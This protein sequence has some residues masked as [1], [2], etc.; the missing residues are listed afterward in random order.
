MAKEINHIFENITIEE[1][2][3][4]LKEQR[5]KILNEFAKAYL[6][7]TGLLP[8]EVELVSSQDCK[9]FIIE[10]VYSFRKKV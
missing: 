9:G 10:T 4:K 2:T 5:D 8:S 7:E 6:A 1:A 3:L